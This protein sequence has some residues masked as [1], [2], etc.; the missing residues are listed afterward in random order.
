MAHLDT[1]TVLLATADAELHR[2][3]FGILASALGYP[4]ADSGR[5]A[6]AMA[7]LDTLAE[8]GPEVAAQAVWT[9]AAAAFIRG[10]TVTGAAQ[11]ARFASRPPTPGTSYLAAILAA[12]DSAAH[13]RLAA[14]VLATDTLH[15]DD[16]SGSLGGPFARA[17]LYLER[18]RWLRESDRAAEAEAT[19]LFHENSYLRGWPTREMQSGEV[20]AVLSGLA[21]LHR[22]ELAAEQ[23]RHDDGCRL[24]RRAQSLWK[25]ADLA[26]APLV[27]R[28]GRVAAAC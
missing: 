4:V 24:A 23:G 19:W 12:L 18:G 7:A 13:G 16:R 26:F 21:K 1:A 11:A 14:A 25:D 22:A 8:G 6:H 27:A 15:A 20:D 28:A 5:L 2:Q 9:L 17:V 3:A 10:D